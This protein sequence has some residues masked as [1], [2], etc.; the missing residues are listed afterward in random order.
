MVEGATVRRDHVQGDA[1]LCIPACRAFRIALSIAAAEPVLDVPDVVPTLKER[2][3]RLVVS[4]V[5][6]IAAP[7]A[8][9]SEP[10]VGSIDAALLRGCPTSDHGF[11]VIATPRVGADVPNSGNPAM[12][13]SYTRTSIHAGVSAC[14]RLPYG[15]LEIVVSRVASGCTAGGIHGAAAKS[16]DAAAP[17]PQPPPRLRSAS[18]DPGAGDEDRP[19][20][21][22]GGGSATSQARSQPLTA[23]PPS[24]RKRPRGTR[25]F[26]G[27]GACKPGLG[28]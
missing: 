1:K 24:A 4:A 15:V 23:L 22:R 10:R 5:A 21:L 28:S 3:D 2:R 6:D 9:I 19:E 20:P 14:Q 13:S 12:T 27:R 17:G 25:S 7:R 26:R 16:S 18:R 8:E 11:E